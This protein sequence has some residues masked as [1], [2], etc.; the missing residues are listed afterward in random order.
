MFKTVLIITIIILSLYLLGRFLDREKPITE[1]VIIDVRSNSEWKEWHHPRA[2]HIPYY[3]IGNLE[4]DRNIPIILYCNSKRR[5]VLAKQTL[6]QKGYS[7]I[8]IMNL[9][10]IKAMN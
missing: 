9:E 7:N 4:K 5:A 8:T 6:V 3:E 2:I 1:T 10:E